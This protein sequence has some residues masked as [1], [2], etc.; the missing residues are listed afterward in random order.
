MRL[1]VDHAEQSIGVEAWSR[2]EEELVG[3]AAGAASAK[4]QTPKS[5]D[6]QELVGFVLQ[7]TNELAG[8]GI[9]RVDA[10]VT[11]VANQNVVASRAK[12]LRRK[13][14]S[15][16]SYKVRVLAEEFDLA[17]GRVV[18]VHDASTE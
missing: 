9:E 10:A 12:I 5:I 18:D 1:R 4:G 2:R 17:S 16:G 6:Q 15:P 13:G 11:Q 8:L 14:Q 7:R 3:V